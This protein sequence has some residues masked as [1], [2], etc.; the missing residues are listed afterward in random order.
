ME[1]VKQVLQPKVTQ[2]SVNW[3]PPGG[4]TATKPFPSVQSDWS[5]STP[6]TSFTTLTKHQHTLRN[7]STTISITPPTITGFLSKERVQSTAM[8]H[9]ES[10]RLPSVLSSQSEAILRNAAWAK[11]QCLH[12]ELSSK[13]T[14]NNSQDI[15]EPPPLK[16]R[17]V[18]D[19]PSDKEDLVNDIVSISLASNVSFFPYTHFVSSQL[20]PSLK[21]GEGN[22][23]CPVLPWNGPMTIHTRTHSSSRHQTRKRKRHHP[24]GHHHQSLTDQSSSLSSLAK[25]SAT[26]ICS[27]LKTVVN[28]ASFGM[29]TMETNDTIPDGERIEDQVY[30]QNKQDR[31]H[32]NQYGRLMLPKMYYKSYSANQDQ[33]VGSSAGPTGSETVQNEF[34]I[35]RTHSSSSDS[36]HNNDAVSPE[37]QFVEIEA[38][39]MED[40]NT[41]DILLHDD[42]L[43]PSQP[44]YMALVQ[45]Q[46][47]SGGWP[48]VPSLA[49][50]TGS[51]MGYIRSLPCNQGSLTINKADD[52][53]SGD[54][55][56][57]L[58][59]VG[60]LRCHFKQ[61][62]VEW[63]VLVLKAMEWVNRNENLIPVSM[64]VA[65][66]MVESH[67]AKEQSK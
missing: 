59:A 52:G 36:D 3:P 46:L 56:A 63:E 26:F 29:V 18:S 8:L 37:T 44:D 4:Y 45:L 47:P 32:W 60:C 62:V 14:R 7:G 57:T 30:H 41:D 19:T 20:D 15:S 42:D 21:E 40:D 49:R 34:N 61:F 50:A 38:S 54:V 58:M 13:R 5:I 11:M 6:Y 43:G 1:I 12:D 64:G 17:K 48:L 33:S 10:T 25:R 9:H 65:Q 27:T 53:S 23:P 66:S 39:P 28:I 22:I 31:I 24:H 2:V 67:F 35:T 55:W 51:N 16:K